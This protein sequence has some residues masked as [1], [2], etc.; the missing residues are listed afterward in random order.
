MAM[1]KLVPVVRGE[2][3]GEKHGVR[4]QQGPGRWQADRKKCELGPKLL[5]SWPT[6]NSSTPS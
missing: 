2:G 6:H 5:A 4:M 3:E 1:S